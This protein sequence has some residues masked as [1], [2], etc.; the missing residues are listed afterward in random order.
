M[1]SSRKEQ[2]V[3]KLKPVLGPVQLV[4][5]GVGVI[6]GA[7]ERPLCRNAGRRQV[8]TDIFC[9]LTVVAVARSGPIS[10]CQQMPTV[11][12]RAASRPVELITPN[13]RN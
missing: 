6:V 9:G 3:M 2:T 4:F 5:Y 10:R 13:V 12:A 7:G 1:P 8:I 11:S